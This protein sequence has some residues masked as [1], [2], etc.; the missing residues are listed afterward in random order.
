MRLSIAIF[1]LLLLP[2]AA[3][4]ADDADFNLTAKNWWCSD[5]CTPDVTGRTIAIEQ[6]GNAVRLTIAGVV[7]E[8]TASTTIAKRT[9]GTKYMR[10]I[11]FTQSECVGIPYNHKGVAD[12]PPP[13]KTGGLVLTGP[14][15]KYLGPFW[16]ILSKKEI[17]R[18]RK[19][20][21]DL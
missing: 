10:R 17:E 12:A 1:G 2:H 3:I 8:G 6:K 5:D 20:D 21:D 11:L 19:E 14:R 7:L 15:C 4:A 9:T 16:T 18:M 13:F